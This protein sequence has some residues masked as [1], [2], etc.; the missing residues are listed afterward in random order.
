MVAATI[1]GVVYVGQW[2]ARPG[3]RTAD[4]EHAGTANIGAANP[5]QRAD[6]AAAA[7]PAVPYRF[8]AD[9]DSD[10]L[11]D[12]KEFI[13][14]TDPRRTDTDGDG[15]T[16][17]SEVLNGYDPL[18]AGSARLPEKPTNLTQRYLSQGGQPST[19]ETAKVIA[20]LAREPDLA[21]QLPVVKPDASA[22]ANELGPYRQT[23]AQLTLPQENVSYNELAR[24]AL[25]D[26]YDHAD[27]IAAAFAELA[28][29]WQARKVPAAAAE[30]HA[31]VVGLLRLGN[32]LFAELHE[33]KQDPVRII[34]NMERGRALAAVA[35]EIRR[36]GAL[37]K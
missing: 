9:T 24:A 8:D 14:G 21:F 26:K 5:A 36:D 12:A 17:A 16:D 35:E 1:A 19:L 3:A 28:A 7:A 34:W 11:A 27:R 4:D 22:D 32:E 6:A 30:I 37:L 18:I 2:F 25:Q 15:H 31:K 13:Y 33:A 20:F 29:V 10:G 23:I